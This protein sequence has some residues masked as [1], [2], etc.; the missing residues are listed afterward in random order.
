[1]CAGMNRNLDNQLTALPGLVL[2]IGACSAVPP[3]TVAAV[4]QDELL[5]LTATYDTTLGAPACGA[6]ASSCDTGALVLGRAPLG[7][8]PNAPNTI[9]GTCPD[10]TPGGFHGGES[11]D[12]LVVH[13]VD[14]SAFEAGTT[15]QIDATVWVLSTMYDRVDLFQSAGADTPAWQRVA[16]LAPTGTGLQTLSATYVLPAGALQA[17]RAQI[18]F[19]GSPSP[20]Y[21]GSSNERDDL[22][23]TVVAVDLPPSANVISPVANSQV[24]APIDITAYATDDKGI[25]RVE[26]YL[27]QAVLLGTAIRSPYIVSW[28]P[29]GTAN[30]PHILTSRSFDTTGHVRTSW[31]IPIDVENPGPIDTTPP[32]TSVDAPA[33]G[34]TVSGTVALQASASD[35][36]GVARVELY[37]DAMRIATATAPPYTASWDSGRFAN[38]PH[39]LT[40]KAYDAV[41]NAAVSAPVTVTVDNLAPPA[42]LATYDP[43]ISTARCADIGASCDS[44]ALLDGRWFSEPGTPS[45]IGR[46]CADGTLGSYHGD[47]SLDRLVVSTLDGTALAAG[48]TVRIDATVWA[49][50]SFT[51]DALDLYAAANAAS[52][53]WVSL[54]TLLPTT[55]G[56]QTLSATYVLPAGPVQAIR[57]Q[58]RYGSSTGPCTSGDFNDRDDLVFAVQP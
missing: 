44:G 34:S 22:A 2:A 30:G 41:G 15:V 37:V 29:G 3:P 5:A 20:C 39:A 13:T 55:G 21:I 43:A 11:I 28:N 17:V 12:R 8:E 51:F 25:A 19:Q 54:G 36:G 46:T 40:S 18:R 53:S 48:K 57:G 42:L 9:H 16:T 58:F 14:G 27:D 32:A 49:Y 1:M 4:T 26:F 52:P 33:D 47:E 7:R 50:A 38:G 10:A 35:D 24:V 23:F 56:A 6:M 31:P 45:T